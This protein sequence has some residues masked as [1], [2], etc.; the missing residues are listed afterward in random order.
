MQN[1]FLWF[2]FF[3]MKRIKLTQIFTQNS[4]TKKLN[5]KLKLD[6][7]YIL[8]LIERKGFCMI[9]IIK[10]SYSRSR[11]NTVKSY[12]G[13]I[14]LPKNNSNNLVFFIINQNTSISLL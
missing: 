1:L 8:L 9:V 12:F 4:P 10:N 13:R 7:L 11:Y 6:K 14:Q 5:S 3:K 2:F